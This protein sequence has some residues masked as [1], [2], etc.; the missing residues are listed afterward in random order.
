MSL[1]LTKTAAEIFAPTDGGGAPRG[2]SMGEA[3]TW[4]TELENQLAALLLTATRA[5]DATAV[6]S[7]TTLTNDTVLSVAVEAST[8]YFFEAHL[9]FASGATPDFKAALGL[10]SGATAEG[11][12]VDTA[13]GAAVADLTSAQ[14]F[15]GGTGTRYALMKGRITVS[16]TAGNAVVKWAQNTSDASDTQLLAG[17]S[18]VLRKGA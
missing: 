4:G 9:F 11:V 18:L 8:V 17:S 12:L 5:T 7:S 16:S 13:A 1:T 10:P 15:D 14:V 3:Q 6:Q 2:A